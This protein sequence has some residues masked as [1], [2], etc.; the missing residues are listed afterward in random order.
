MG[1]VEV[2]DLVHRIEDR[3][4]L[5]KQGLGLAGTL[6]L[7]DVCLCQAGA[8]QEAVSNRAERL[9]SRTACTT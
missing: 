7:A 1:L 6:K 2:A 4:A 3:H 5:L 9:V 8:L